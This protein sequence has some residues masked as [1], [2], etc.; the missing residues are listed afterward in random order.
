MAATG[1]LSDPEQVQTR[2]G[3]KGPF[4]VSKHPVSPLLSCAGLPHLAPTPIPLGTDP[5]VRGGGGV[6]QSWVTA[7]VGGLSWPQ[8]VGFASGAAG[9]AW[10]WGTQ[11][12]DPL[13][14]QG[15]VRRLRPGRVAYWVSFN[16]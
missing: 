15:V 4:L 12:T 11:C 14:S 1:S 9:K 7:L 16:S 10:R 13:C 3:E 8:A 5:L 6:V 2:E